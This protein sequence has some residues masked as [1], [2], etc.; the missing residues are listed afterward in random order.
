MGY[1]RTLSVLL[2]RAPP[3][4]TTTFR[5]QCSSRRLE[6]FCS[7]D[8]LAG[9]LKMASDACA[10][11]LPEIGQSRG[12]P[13]QGLVEDRVHKIHVPESR[14]GSGCITNQARRARTDIADNDR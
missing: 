8:A 2:L 1:G 7:L 11:L 14:V 5:A 10:R 13:A 3:S 9:H 12:R 6:R 4:L